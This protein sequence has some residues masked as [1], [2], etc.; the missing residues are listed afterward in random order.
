MELRKGLWLMLF[1][2]FHDLIRMDVCYF[3]Y[4]R[5]LRNSPCKPLPSLPRRR[6]HFVLRPD[7]PLGK[8]LLRPN[9]R[10]STDNRISA[11]RPEALDLSRCY[12]RSCLF[13]DCSGVP[14]V[15]PLI[16]MRFRLR[17]RN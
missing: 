16:P 1:S 6:V 12:A 13:N 8:Y 2:G 15:A 5:D 4:R 9:V 10:N 11:G 3:N 7:Q 14:N 17:F